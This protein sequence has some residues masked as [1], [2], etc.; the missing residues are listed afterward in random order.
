VN[1][2][3]FSRE[4][5]QGIAKRAMLLSY[6]KG[7]NP[8]WADAYKQLAQAS[9]ELDEAMDRSEAHSLEYL[10]RI[11]GCL[12]IRFVEHEMVGRSFFI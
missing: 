3:G 6:Q 2:E 10:E 9:E 4:E 8:F 5:L 12:W 1:L 11:K 7:I